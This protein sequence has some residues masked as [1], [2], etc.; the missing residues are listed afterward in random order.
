MPRS[1]SWPDGGR[2]HKGRQ[3]RILNRAVLLRF[4]AC[5][6]PDQGAAGRQSSALCGW[7]TSVLRRR[8]DRGQ[9]KPAVFRIFLP[10]SQGMGQ[11]R[12]PSWTLRL[13]M[14]VEQGGAHSLLL[15]SRTRSQSAG[16]RLWRG[17]EKFRLT[18]GCCTRLWL[19]PRARPRRGR[20]HRSARCGWGTPALRRRR[21]RGQPKP[22]LFRMFLPIPQGMGQRRRRVLGAAIGGV[23]PAVCGA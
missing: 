8:C 18:S 14:T 16:P 1:P 19:P 10:I 12:R 17:K 11:R 22:A 13:A 2:P 15:R 9:P 21:N 5:P 23:H 4:A 7:G 6:A 20:Q 3:G